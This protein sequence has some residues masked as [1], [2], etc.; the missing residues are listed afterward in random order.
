MLLAPLGTHIAHSIP[1]R[2]LRLAFAC[3]LLLTS[4]RMFYALLKG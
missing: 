2:L 3:F 4:L 1:P